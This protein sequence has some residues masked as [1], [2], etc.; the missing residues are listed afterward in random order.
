MNTMYR[1][2][3]LIGFFI[4]AL[5]FNLTVNH[6]YSQIPASLEKQVRIG[7]LQNQFTTP[8]F[9]R[10]FTGVEYVGMKW[11][12]DY[13][14]QD[15]SVIER[16][17]VAAQNFTDYLGGSWERFAVYFDEGTVSYTIFPVIHEEVGKFDFPAVYVDGSDVSKQFRDDVDRLDETIVAD[18]IVNTV[19]NTRLGLT[20]RRRVY[21]FSQQYHDNYFIKEYTFINTGNVDYD[22]EIELNAPLYSVRMGWGVRYSTC[23]EGATKYDNQQSWGKFSWVTKRGD[24]APNDYA[25]HAGEQIT[26]AN[27]IV[28]WLR[29]S[30]TWAGQSD[31]R[32]DW[33]N[34]GAPDVNASGRLCS[35]QIAGIAVLHVDK[36]AS[37]HSDDPNQPYLNGW[38][39][40]D[41]FV[42]LADQ[43]GINDADKMRRAY[44]MLEGNPFPAASMGGTNRYYEDNTQ[45]IID[46]RSPWLLH[47]DIGGTSIWLTYGPFDIPFGDSIRIVEC[48]AIA[49]LNRTMSEQIGGR[50]VK[51]HRNSNDQGPF[52]LPPSL[53]GAPLGGTTN[54]EDYYKNAWFYTGWDSILQTFGRAKRVYDSDFNLPQPPLPPGIVQVNSGGDRITITWTA[55]PS[56]G[57]DF[58]G[59]K[60][61]R[62]VAKADTVF[63]EIFACGSGTDNPSIVYTFDDI[64][65]VR[66]FS[67]YYYVQAFN[68]GTNNPGTTNPAGLLY[69]GRFYTR[70]LQPAYLRRQAGTSLKDIRIVPNPFN[71]KARSINYP[72]EQDKIGFLNIPAFCKIRIFT[73]SGDMIYEIDHKNG[74]GDEYWNSITSSRQVVV[75]GLYIAHF[76][77]TKDY[78]D[79][80]TG[81][82]LYRKGDNTFRKFI[83]IR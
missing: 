26:E 76:E 67:Y 29:C 77:V 60:V 45:S 64:T 23:R 68:D 33:D 4:C 78:P 12:A 20:M 16:S 8:G 27:P 25:S 82:I 43:L 54:D 15:N 63:Q 56:E 18:R 7:S 14:N 81:K 51:A 3:T 47:N 10:A 17:W 6:A 19:V 34:V 48:E 57:S 24:L 59:Y 61:F 49:G 2:K 65:P 50:W 21:A 52:P 36:S 30:F 73:E 58:G 66:G 41:A 53:N 42:P 55:S 46:R 70:T 38:H 28:Q 62:A 31:L 32:S 39:A 80:E 44:E 40:S 71:I 22:D 37:D 9:E 79:P 74:S 35:P 75:S 5:F 11:P 13:L 83:I 69:S 1:N 72:N